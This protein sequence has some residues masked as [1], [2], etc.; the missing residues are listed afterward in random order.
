M[1][2]SM[3]ELGRMERAAG[4]VDDI[5][6]SYTL[7]RKADVSRHNAQPII[8]TIGVYCTTKYEHDCT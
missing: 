2:T 3:A 1:K 6:D 4:V 7:K 5:E 8:H